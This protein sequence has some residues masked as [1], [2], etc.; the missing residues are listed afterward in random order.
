MK[1][2]YPSK[3]DAFGL[4]VPANRLSNAYKFV[5]EVL[6]DISVEKAMLIVGKA[7]SSIEH[8]NGYA[9]IGAVESLDKDLSM[10]DVT[11]RYRLLAHLTTD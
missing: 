9:I 3:F 5:K 11:G 7:A 4:P 6:T 8:D 10:I 2:E 1:E